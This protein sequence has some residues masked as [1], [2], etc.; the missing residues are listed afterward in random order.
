MLIPIVFASNENY[1]PYMSAAMQSVMENASEEHE[2]IFF[3]LYKKLEEE[4]IKKL[5]IQVD[6]YPYF[7]IQFTKVSHEFIETY[8]RMLTPWLLKDF[9]KIIYMDCD[10][11]CNTDIS[12]IFSIDIENNI[13]AGAPD[14]P[15]ISNGKPKNYVNAGFL[16]MNLKEFRNKY[17][18]DY[19]LGWIQNNKYDYLDQDMLNKAAKNSLFIL[20]Q[21]LNFLN[22]SWDISHAPK[23]LIE[24]YADAKTNPEI[25]HYTTTKPW[26]ME[27]NP[28]LFHLFW[29]YST[30]TPFIDSIIENMQKNK[31]IGQRVKNLFVKVLKNKLLGK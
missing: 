8:F 26:T 12:N 21:K 23:H 25:I 14:V 27:L 2:Y 31:L 1:A 3:I 29:K 24:E 9:D 6:A 30:R 7:S 22:T 5:Y 28:P 4:T 20:S 10:I 19:M 16:I 15:L 13:L 17:T 18:F 11:I